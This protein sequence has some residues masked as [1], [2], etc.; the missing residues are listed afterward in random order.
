MSELRQ[1]DEKYHFKTYKRYPITLVKGEGSRV[2]DDTGKEYV[3]ALAGIAV[4]NTGHCHPMVVEAIQKQ[5]GQLMHVSNFVTTEP[6]VMLTKRLVEMSNHDRVFF[7]NSGTEAMEGAL[8]IVRRYANKHDKK[9]PI[10]SMSGAFHG[11][12]LGALAMG[13]PKYQEG[14]GQMLPGFIQVPFNDIKAVE[15]IADDGLAAVFIEPI[16]GEGGVNVADKKYMNDL[17]ALCHEYK[18]LLV[19][20]EVQCGI[21][22]M[23]TFFAYEY[24]DVI[25]DI[26]AIAKGLGGGFP[27]GAVLALEEAADVIEYGKHGTTFG[28]NPLACA[29]TLATIEAIHSEGMLKQAKEKGEWLRERIRMEMPGETGIEEVRGV[30]LMNGV[31]LNFNGAGVALRMLEKGVIANVTASNVVRLVPPLNI[32]Y[33]DLEII[34]DAMIESIAEEKLAQEKVKEA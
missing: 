32:S 12:T 17:R 7:C 31:Q 25:P 29:A 5:A 23:G 30:G 22:R 9:G 16:Q 14:F 19:F 10:V 26:V 15:A 28:G 27:V 4:N 1:I 18:A 6:Q 24:F 11:R 21:G 33:E 13:Q 8:K 2:W 3:D 20:D 34:V